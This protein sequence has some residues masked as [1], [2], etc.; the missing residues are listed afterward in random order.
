MRL[1][2]TLL[3][4][5]P[6]VCAAPGL[7]SAQDF[8]RHIDEGY[9]QYTPRG[10]LPWT[11]PEDV[12]GAA[13]QIAVRATQLAR[14]MQNLEG[15]SPL[16]AEARRFARTAQLFE[17][18]VRSGAPYPQVLS[19]FEELQRDYYDMRTAF[20]R[21]HRS[22]HVEGVVELWTSLVAN[23]ERLALTLGVEEDALCA[24]PPPGRGYGR[25]DRSDRYDRY[26]SYDPRYDARRQYVP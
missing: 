17:R 18:S 14:T 22:H 13:R 26:G 15:Y 12:R 8:D 20:F 23:F 24:L 21:A 5:V 25:Y 4:A 16:A 10:A 1:L 6:V 19:S 2:R 11:G 3:F 9:R 7:A